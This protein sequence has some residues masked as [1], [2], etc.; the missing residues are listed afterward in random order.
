MTS[1]HRMAL[2][3]I[4]ELDRALPETAEY[5]KTVLSPFGCTLSF[6]WESAVCAYFDYGRPETV[7][8][9]ADMDAL[10]ICEATGL[11]FASEHAGK[12]HACG[13]DGHM[14]ILLSLA[15]H[16]ARVRMRQTRN[17]LLI[18]QPA[19][20]TTGGAHALCECG[21]LEKHHVTSIYGLHLWPELAKGTVAA[22]AGGQMARSCELTVE[23]EGKSAH[24]AHWRDGND[25]L[26]AASRF[27]D[28]AYRLAEGKTCVLRFG[29][30]E[31]GT[32]R[33]AV[34]AHSRL[35]GS[36]RCFDDTLFH[37]LCAGLDALAAEIS[38]ET[39][40]TVRVA[41]SDGYP[42]MNNDPALLAQARESFPIAEAVPSYTT[43]DFSEYERRVPGV[44][45]FLGTGGPALHTPEFDFD[46]SVLDTGLALFCSL[47]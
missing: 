36:L 8:F 41:Y 15:E 16:L 3:R 39:G 40:C 22:C 47:L 17:V 46:M 4:P 28:R 14:A 32:V 25:A 21:I 18:F 31:S 2:H 9:R 33:N 20:E 24:I 11:P 43:D 12:M 34:S 23:I 45:F 37:T 30:L 13:H 7:A 5:L 44:Y 42:P 27:L 1:E 38:R 35:E 19:E 29:R 6:P 10:P 26:Y